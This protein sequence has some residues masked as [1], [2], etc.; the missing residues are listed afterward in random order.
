[1]YNPTSGNDYLVC[2]PLNECSVI[3]FWCWSVYRLIL[4]SSCHLVCKLFPSKVC[5]TFEFCFR[6][7]VQRNTQYVLVFD[8]FVIV[9]CLASLILCTRSI[10][11]GLRLRKVSVCQY[12]LPPFLTSPCSLSKQWG[13]DIGS[14][15]PFWGPWLSWIPLSDCPATRHYQPGV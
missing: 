2:E 10:V 9:I 6:F 11:L 14:S 8:A 13:L 4:F 5:L 7:S 15:C 3:C 12:F 1:M